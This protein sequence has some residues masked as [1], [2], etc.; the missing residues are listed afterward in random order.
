MQGEYQTIARLSA[1]FER[2]IVARGA[3]ATGPL[4]G[5]KRSEKLD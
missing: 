4:V 5:E 3:F 2:G 1:Q